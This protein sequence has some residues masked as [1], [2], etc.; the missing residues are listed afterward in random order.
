MPKYV[1]HCAFFFLAITA[2]SGV[3]MR[4]YAIATPTQIVAYDHILHA[5]SH[6]AILGWTF[7][8][9]LIIYF[10]LAWK[11]VQQ[12]KTGNYTDYHNISHNI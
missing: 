9:V 10:K 6:A 7:L 11:H 5:H 4:L 8:A 3:W 2:L 1:T 12:K